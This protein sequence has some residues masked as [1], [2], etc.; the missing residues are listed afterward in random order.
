MKNK[1][2]LSLITIF[3]LITVLVIHENSLV[4]RFDALI[5]NLIGM[6]QSPFLDR[7][8]LSFTKIGDAYESLY[9]FIIFGLFLIAQKKKYAFYTLTLATGFGIIFTQSMKLLVERARP[10][11]NM[12]VETTF[13]FPSGHAAI[14][15]IFL[16]GSVLLVAPLIKNIFIRDVFVFATFIL[17][18]FV[19][20]SRL[21]LSVH[22]ASDVIAGILLG[23]MCFM[24]AQMMIKRS[25][26]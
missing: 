26:L 9:I 2:L 20:I 11:S 1:I 25:D 15:T 6:V 12:L 13:S 14:S 8:A 21:Y 18:P 19:A 17:F 23:Y 24:L 10:I 7:F 3:L 4:M 16:L 5:A 22:F